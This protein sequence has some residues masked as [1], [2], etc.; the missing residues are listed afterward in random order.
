[1]INL[2]HFCSNFLVH[3]ILY[4]FVVCAYG[5]KRK[6]HVGWLVV[7]TFVP[8]FVLAYVVACICTQ[9]ISL[10][11]L[12]YSHSLQSLL[13]KVILACLALAHVLALWCTSTREFVLGSSQGM[14]LKNT[15]SSVT[16]VQYILLTVC[17]HICVSRR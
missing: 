12:K 10:M 13:A 1:M 3:F 2:G 11:F 17:K 7:L 9:D 4:I 14:M 16:I 5:C 8:T 6:F 15:G